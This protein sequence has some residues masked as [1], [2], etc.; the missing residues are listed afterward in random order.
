MLL[1]DTRNDFVRDRKGRLVEKEPRCPEC[2]SNNLIREK[3]DADDE[4]PA[5]DFWNCLS[6]GTQCNFNDEGEQQ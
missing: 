2:R 3:W 5:A 1:M 6:C 4:S